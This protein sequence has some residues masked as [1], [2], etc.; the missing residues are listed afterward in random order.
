MLPLVYIFTIQ[1]SSPQALT[2][3]RTSY[4]VQHLEARFSVEVTYRNY[5]AFPLADLTFRQPHAKYLAAGS[6]IVV[7]VRG[8]ALF[9]QQVIEATKTLL[10]HHFGRMAVSFSDF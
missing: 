6:T 10:E 5:F 4:I 2:L 7:T 9:S 8:L 3:Y 1:N